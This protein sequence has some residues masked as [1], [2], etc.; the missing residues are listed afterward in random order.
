MNTNNRLQHLKKTLTSLTFYT[1]LLFFILGINNSFS[2]N[3]DNN[4]CVLGNFGIDGDLYSGSL[5]YG[6]TSPAT[7]Q[8]TDDWFTGATGTGVGVIQTTNSAAIKALLQGTGD[9]VFEARMNGY[10]GAVVNGRIWYDAVYARDNFGGTGF[11][12]PTAFPVSSKNTQPPSSWSAGPANVL[13]KNDLLDVAAHIRR[14]GSTNASP[15]FLTGLISRA[16]PGGA[17]YMDMEFFSK[18][19]LTLQALVFHLLEMS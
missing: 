4:G 17:A 3:I 5:I 8:G 14:S 16:E 1:L 12:D 11:V 6:D 13:G 9:P 7:P 2:Q 15:L 18:M 19:L 10:F